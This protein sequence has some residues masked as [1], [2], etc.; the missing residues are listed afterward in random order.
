MCGHGRAGVGWSAG[1][2]ERR[3]GGCK[4]RHGWDADK[5]FRAARSA[6]LAL[7][8]DWNSPLL[9]RPRTNGLP[10]QPV[11]SCHHTTFT[12]Q[13]CRTPC[14]ELYAHP[15]A[16]TLSH[17]SHVRACVLAGKP[18]ESGVDGHSDA[19][20]DSELG[21]VA[22][23]VAPNTSLNLSFPPAILWKALELKSHAKGASRI[24][25]III[26]AAQLVLPPEQAAAISADVKSGALRLPSRWTL[27][28]AQKQL[29]ICSLH[30]QRHLF[31]RFDVI[32]MHM[33]DAS[34]QRG[35]NF[36]VARTDDFRM[37]KDLPHEDR[38]SLPLGSIMSRRTLP[39]TCLGY[40]SAGLAEKLACYIHMGRMEAGVA[41]VQFDVWRYSVRG[42]CTDQGL[43]FKIAD[44][45]HVESDGSTEDLLRKY[46][47]GL[48]RLQGAG[49][50]AF[51][52]PR[53]IGVPGRMHILWDALEE[54][55]KSSPQWKAFESGLRSIT[56]LL[57]ERAL[58]QVFQQACCKSAAER[59]MFEHWHRD[60]I[61][62]RWEYL[63]DVLNPLL[64][65]LHVF[66]ERFSL[67]AMSRGGSGEGSIKPE[68][69]KACEEL[70]S[71]AQRFHL[72]AEQ[73]RI[74]AGAVGEEAR[75]TEGCPCHEEIWTAGGSHRKRQKTFSE[76][77]G[78]LYKQCPWKGRRARDLARGRFDAL[79]SK[80]FS[81]SSPTLQSLLGAAPGHLQAEVFD[82]A[83]HVKSRLLE[84]VRD[85]ERFWAVVP[86]RLAAIW[87]FGSC[88]SQESRRYAAECVQSWDKLVADG[89]SKTAHR[90]AFRFLEEGTRLGGLMRRLAQSGVCDPELRWE[91]KVLSLLPTV[92]RRIEEA[93]AVIHRGTLD[94]QR[95]LPARINADAPRLVLV[96]VG[97]V[98]SAYPPH[99]RGIAHRLKQCPKHRL[100]IRWVGFASCAMGRGET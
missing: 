86:W 61:D 73:V 3:E 4:A 63:E 97:G 24:R 80:L 26:L 33:L 19:D 48:E 78:G 59:A 93:H 82:F 7:S 43:E 85:K 75:W 64:P 94:K 10:I 32:C 74:I 11:Y 56:Q 55:C 77:T 99:M 20:G 65:K 8:F 88:E 14:P 57:G 67:A 96:W 69:V 28:R 18:P 76:A 34:P 84:M 30:F 95:I 92:E 89:M 66:F 71:D 83:L 23:S 36:L 98:C 17:R 39:L 49:A 38:L 45:P 5:S 51:L 31:A 62:W 21:D 90:E 81:P 29:D 22:E 42:L 70:K 46:E 35:W 52:L 6:L 50:E 2:G 53:C 60:H 9:T 72:L 79:R 47:Q 12:A 100:G 54:A 41:G 44:A 58:R 25:D 87:D 40:G 1:L 13:P 27:D 37:P 16:A 15:C 91:L 68:C